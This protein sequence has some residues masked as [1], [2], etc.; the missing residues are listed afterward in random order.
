MKQ[1][2][3]QTTKMKQ[4]KTIILYIFVAT[5]NANT[6]LLGTMSKLIFFQT[7]AIALSKSNLIA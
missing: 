3:I 7:F 5:V 6:H 1:L 4:L 2:K